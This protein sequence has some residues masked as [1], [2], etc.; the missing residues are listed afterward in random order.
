MSHSRSLPELGYMVQSRTNTI[1]E[2]LNKANIAQPSLDHGPPSSDVVLPRP[3]R[4]QRAEL[5]EALDELQALVLGPTSYL[6]YTSITS[7]R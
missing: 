2:L 3:I 1:H 5:L 6:Y 7:D 4:E